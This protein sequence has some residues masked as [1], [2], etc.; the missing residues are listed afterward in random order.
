[1]R[2]INIFSSARWSDQFNYLGRSIVYLEENTKSCCTGGKG[3]S[4]ALNQVAQIASLANLILHHERAS[5]KGL[6]ENVFVC[7][8]INVYLYIFAC[9]RTDGRSRNS[10]VIATKI[11]NGKRTRSTNITYFSTPCITSSYLHRAI[12][13]S[14]KKLGAQVKMRKFR[15]S[16]LKI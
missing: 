2:H 6:D 12:N 8:V 11:N 15:M 5:K 3:V 4:F 14:T 9:W 1:M 13:T 16:C 10:K 7:I